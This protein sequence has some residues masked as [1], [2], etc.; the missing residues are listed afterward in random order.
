MIHFR[1]IVLLI[2]FYCSYPAHAQLLPQDTADKYWQQLTHSNFKEGLFVHLDKSI[3]TNNE[4]IWFSAYFLN[5]Q[6]ALAQ[7]QEFISVS[8][9][10]PLTKKVYLE[11]KFIAA[12]G[13]SFGNFPVPDTIPPGNYLFTAFGNV[14]NLKQQPIALYQQL[15][16]IKSVIKNNFRAFIQ[17]MD[18]LSTKEKF[19]IQVKAQNL[20]FLPLKKAEVI[21]SMDGLKKETA[22]TNADGIA[23]I[24]LSKKEKKGVVQVR[25][26]Y[27]NEFQFLSATIP[28][29]NMDTNAVVQFYPESGSLMAGVV[30]NVLMHVQTA[31]GKPIATKAVLYR[32]NE[33]ED[34]LIVNSS[35][36]CSFSFIPAHN[37]PMHVQLF[38]K[39]NIAD[40][41]FHKLPSPAADAVK[42]TTS[43]AVFTDTL[44]FQLNASV[45]QEALLF[46]Y[47]N[48][49]LL[50]SNRITISKQKRK[51]ILPFENEDLLKGICT[52]TM[53]DT[54]GNVLAERLFFRQT[55]TEHTI[56]LKT[57]KASYTRHEKVKLTIKLDE[58]AFKDDVVASVAVVQANRISVI[59]PIDVETHHLISVL[60]QQLPPVKGRV[61][62]NRKHLE[63]LLLM[64]P[65]PKQRN[66]FATVDTSFINLQVKANVTIENKKIKTPQQM[67]VFADTS[68]V[69]LETDSSGT[70][71]LK[72][73]ILITEQGKRVLLAVNKSDERPFSINMSE[74]FI[75]I[76]NNLA[77]PAAFEH[78]VLS[79]KLLEEEQVNDDIPGIKR[80]KEIVV[81]G[82]TKE[83]YGTGPGGFGANVCGDYVCI[84]KILNCPNHFNDA[85]NRGPQDGDMLYTSTSRTT[86]VRY[87]G[88]TN[89]RNGSINRNTIRIPGIYTAKEFFGVEQEQK[90]VAEPEYRSTIYWRPGLLLN[91]GSNTE[92]TFLTSDI[93]GPFKVI[94]QGIANDGSV[95]YKEMKFSVTY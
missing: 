82:K 83:I 22:F 20:S 50:L 6:S 72:P 17:P 84:Y 33:A 49:Q 12:D 43:E 30:N 64:A 65:A 24:V 31:E 87:N 57:D 3:Y 52:V 61:A 45:E 28:P 2:I 4:Q 46:I 21:Y 9:I 59:N 71:E 68:F 13:F 74:Q 91:P 95:F 18:S 79:D 48:N 34:T 54:S 78:P 5:R 62:E 88:C 89:L 73:Q 1:F 92:L 23:T 60:H 26:N 69:I 77:A 39:K 19:Y 27:E 76:A 93:T 16:T 29:L 8:L 11:S 80:L 81:T 47:T 86:K 56:S 15:I 70:L 67:L 10:S 90:D 41:N 51:F 53:T 32:N 94:L 36:L 14:V 38:T 66:I 58:E 40:T 85:M 42:I 7:Q 35:G 44:Q 55:K 63:Q 25:V 37:E 75:E